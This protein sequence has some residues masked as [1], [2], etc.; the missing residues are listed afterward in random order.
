MG[1]ALKDDELLRVAEVGKRYGFSR[2]TLRYWDQLGIVPPK[3]IGT[4]RGYGP[5]EIE[6][7][8]T[9][10]ALIQAGYSPKQLQGI[11]KASGVIPARPVNEDTV[12]RGLL[13]QAAKGKV[14]DIEVGLDQQKY[15][16]AYK[17]LRRL[18]DEMGLKVTPVKEGETLHV[19]ARKR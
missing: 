7:L 17:R 14:V 15:N 16:T 11:F 13:D 3:Y 18:A 1:T 5:R 2:K 4:H 10:K 6:R 19:R 12:F 8:Q 9:V